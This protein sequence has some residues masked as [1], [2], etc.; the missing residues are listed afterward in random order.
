MVNN[1]IMHVQNV[2]RK[3]QIETSNKYLLT[4][5]RMAQIKKT[6]NIKDLQECRTYTTDKNLNY[7]SSDSLVVS[8]KVKY[9]LTICPPVFMHLPKRNKNI[10]L[11]NTCTEVMV[12]DNSN[13]GTKT[14]HIDL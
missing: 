13:L 12:H 3:L 8:L 7:N 1:H 6:N 2:I 5:I 10:C 14:I 4:S 11:Q 9:V